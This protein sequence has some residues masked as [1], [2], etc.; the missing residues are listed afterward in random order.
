MPSWYL[1][2]LDL[3]ELGARVHLAELDLDPQRL[4]RLLEDL[5]DRVLVRRAGAD[6]HLD[7]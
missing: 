4:E 3:G 7:V 5:G 1:R 6:E 2:V